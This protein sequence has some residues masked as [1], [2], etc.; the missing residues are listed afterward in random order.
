M[1]LQMCIVFLS[2]HMGFVSCHI[3]SLI[4]NNLEDG[5]THARTSTQTY[6]RPTNKQ[7]Y[8]TIHT[9]TINTLFYF[10]NILLE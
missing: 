9:S 4:I 3:T 5:H 7:F 10:Y 1:Q 2:N 8:E 6:Q